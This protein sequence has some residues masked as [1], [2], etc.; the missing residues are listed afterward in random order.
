MLG[1]PPVKLPVSEGPIGAKDLVDAERS[2]SQAFALEEAQALPI[3]RV[4][5]GGDS[6]MG[7]SSGEAAS[8][9]ALNPLRDQAKAAPAPPV[10][11]PASRVSFN[12]PMRAAIDPVHPRRPSRTAHK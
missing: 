5:V 7:G 10:D 9:F 2:P 4:N 6:Q 12:T 1:Q 11:A 8:V 3:A